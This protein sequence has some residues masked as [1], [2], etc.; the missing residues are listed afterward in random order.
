M[1]TALRRQDKDQLLEGLLDKGFLGDEPLELA[2]FTEGN[3]LREIFI[4]ADAVRATGYEPTIRLDGHTLHLLTGDVLSLAGQLRASLIVSKQRKPATRIDDWAD[5]RWK[6]VTA[7]T[8]VDFEG[9]E[10]KYG[11]LSQNEKTLVTMD[12]HGKLHCANDI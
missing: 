7:D 2:V 1:T 12:Q 5:E 3:T 9:A 11:E 4:A 8:L 10:C 6:T